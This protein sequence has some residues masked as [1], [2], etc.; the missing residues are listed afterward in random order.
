MK[1]GDLFQIRLEP[2][3]VRTC[4]DGVSTSNVCTAVTKKTQNTRLR[5][6]STTLNWR[7]P[8]C[9]NTRYKRMAETLQVPQTEWVKE[10]NHYGNFRARAR[11]A[12]NSSR[13]HQQEVSQECAFHQCRVQR[14]APCLLDD[15]LRCPFGHPPACFV[16]QALPDSLELRVAPVLLIGSV[17]LLGSCCCL[18]LQISNLVAN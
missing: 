17:G 18:L 2:C 4:Q 3:E 5:T 8:W 12:N 7:L 6:L 15:I 10:A 9:Y 14:V 11:Q 1:D 16:D 13:P